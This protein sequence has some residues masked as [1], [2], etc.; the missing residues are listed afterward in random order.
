VSKPPWPEENGPVLAFARDGKSLIQPGRLLDLATGQARVGRP[1]ERAVAAALSPD[2]RAA[3]VVEAAAPQKVHLWDLKMGK[4]LPSLEAGATPVRELGFTPDSRSLVVVL[5]GKL[6]LFDW[7]GQKELSSGDAAVTTVSVLPVDPVAGNRYFVAVATGRRV[8]LWAIDGP[9]LYPIP[10]AH[11]FPDAV[12]ALTGTRDGRFVAAGTGR[13]D[14]RLWDV[15]TNQEPHAW[16]VP[17]AVTALA[18]AADGK[19]V[20]AGAGNGT[21]YVF[22]RGP[23]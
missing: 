20:A 21:V 23:R 5:E 19:T 7:A 11:D 14:V 12:R 18:V 15:T 8:T 13:G 3:A 4:E 16:T 1:G 6:K 9:R 22:R 2:G 17:G 10:V